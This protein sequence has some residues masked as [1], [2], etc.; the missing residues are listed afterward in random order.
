MS[1]FDWFSF[2]LFKIQRYRISFWNDEYWNALL[3]KT[4]IKIEIKI[5]FMCNVNVAYS[6]EAPLFVKSLI[7]T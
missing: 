1:I 4:F 5:S 2:C 3:M 6:L 7:F